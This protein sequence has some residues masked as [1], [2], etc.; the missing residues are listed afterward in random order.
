MSK[1]IMIWYDTFDK[2][3]C[4][5]YTCCDIICPKTFAFQR[6]PYHPSTGWSTLHQWGR[7]SVTAVNCGSHNS[8]LCSLDLYLCPHR[9]LQFVFV[10][11]FIKTHNSS[12]SWSLKNSKIMQLDN[13]SCLDLVLKSSLI[14]TIPSCCLT[15]IF[16]NSM[17]GISN[18][19][20]TYELVFL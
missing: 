12:G 13:I 4:N 6:G 9:R 8:L 19:S 17:A 1:T 14:S 7:I 2:Y 18:Q 11:W 3:K 10:I 15:Q 5:F 20:K 16:M